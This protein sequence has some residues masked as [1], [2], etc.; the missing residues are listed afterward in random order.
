MVFEKELSRDKEFD[1]LGFGEVMLRLSPPNR[2]RINQGEIFEKK[3][4]GSE[5]NVMSGISL[6]GLRTGIITKLPDNEIGR[7]VKNKIK[8]YGVS[9]DYLV[10]DRSEN[11]RLGIY[12]YESGSHP[13]KPTVIYDRHQSSVNSISLDEIEPAIYKNTKVFHVSGISLAISEQA[14]EVVLEMIENF[15]ENGVLISFDINYRASLWDEP[16]ARK[17]VESI[18]PYLDILFCSEETFRRML[19]QTGTLDDIMKKFS[20]RYDINIIATT[21]REVISPIKHSWNSKIYS[22]LDAKFFEEEPY[23]EIDVVDRIGSG[24]AYLAG[25]L[26]G[27]LKYKDVQRALEFGNA[28]AA[29]KNT[30]PG[31]M[32]ASEFSEIEQ[33]IKTHQNIGEDSEMNR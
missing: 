32:P 17:T 16:T 28:M 11:K 7:F 29:I 27:L 14:R 23:R 1:A 25:V 3:A 9:D 31:D 24:D 19:Q 2:E 22:K 18:L 20:E 15:K 8:F 13:R 30:I 33:V 26:F 5:L 6:L 12:Y 21:K 10:Y 4:G